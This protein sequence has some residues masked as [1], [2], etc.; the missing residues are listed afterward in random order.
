MT[1]RRQATVE[2][3]RTLAAELPRSYDVVVHG[4]LKFR[5]GHIVWLAFSHD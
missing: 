4:R 5:V 3:V 2:D 1:R